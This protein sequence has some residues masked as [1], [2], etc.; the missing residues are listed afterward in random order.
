MITTNKLLQKQK[1]DA[2]EQIRVLQQ[3][4]SDHLNSI[5]KLKNDVISSRSKNDDIYIKCHEEM[6][7]LAPL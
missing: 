7:K 1:K 4:V 3:Q 5:S 2:E 6:S